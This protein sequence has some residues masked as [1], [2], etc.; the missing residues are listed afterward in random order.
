MKRLVVLATTISLFIAPLYVA[1]ESPI[2][3]HMI[4]I[5]LSSDTIEYAITQESDEPYLKNYL[6]RFGRYAYPYEEF[7]NLTI[8]K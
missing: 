3:S 6:K 7:M 5:K 2:Q 1:F 4:R 8:G